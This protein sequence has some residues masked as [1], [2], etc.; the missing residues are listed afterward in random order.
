MNTLI[1]VFNFCAWLVG[2]PIVIA[3]IIAVLY[4]L[5]V[6]LLEGL[7]VRLR[8]NK[9]FMAWLESKAEPQD[10]DLITAYSWTEGD[11]E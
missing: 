7:R 8:R 4:E 5:G 1:A 3:A 6:L 2:V 10:D 9:R 11:A